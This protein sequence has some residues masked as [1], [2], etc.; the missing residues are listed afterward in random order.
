MLRERTCGVYNGGHFI[1]GSWGASLRKYE[2]DVRRKARVQNCKVFTADK[3]KKGAEGGV[4][5]TEN[6]RL[7]A[8][9]TVFS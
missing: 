4:K 2:A 8:S 9:V 6:A 5:D 7:D 3:K 1:G